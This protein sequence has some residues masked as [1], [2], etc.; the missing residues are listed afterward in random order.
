MEKKD[1]INTLIVDDDKEI[2]TLIGRFL[3]ENNYNCILTQ[4]GYSALEIIRKN[5]LDLV[6]TDIK[7]EGMNGLQLMANAHEKYSY[8]PFIVLTGF[9]QEYSFSKI[10]DQGATDFLT[11]P[12]KLD[13]LKARAKKAVF[14]ARKQKE[15]YGTLEKLK[16]SERKYKELSITDGL[17]NLYNHTH[18]VNQLQKEIERTKRFDH[19][20]SLMLMDVDNFKQ[21]NDAYGHPEGDKFLQ[22]TGETIRNNIR[23]TDSGYRYGG[24][25]FAVILPET[26][27]K[28]AFIAAERI[29]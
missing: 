11:K 17:T 10:I 2:R 15:L 16:E 14:L 29:R 22:R 18:F 9:T 25:E 5:D 20:L 4:D 26:D 1:K 3:S 24:E 6:I 19:P 12:I 8:L 27:D 21:Y 23:S 7:M 28:D 13:M